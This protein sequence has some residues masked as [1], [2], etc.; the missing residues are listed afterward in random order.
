MPR[1]AHRAVTSRRCAP[2]CARPAMNDTAASSPASPLPPSRRNLIVG[3]VAVGA[4]LA[5][6]GFAIRRA[7]QGETAAEVEAFW[8]MN[9]QTPQG[10]ALPMAALRGKPLLLNFWA[11]WCPPCV[12]EFPL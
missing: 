6:A 11:T 12:E 10:Q 2:C 3:G 9:F 4:V 7:R 5:G 1:A 8:G